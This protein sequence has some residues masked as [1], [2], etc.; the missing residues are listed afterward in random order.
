MVILYL[1]YIKFIKIFR[2]SRYILFS[3]NTAT[4]ITVS[5]RILKA[6]VPK[7]VLQFTMFNCM[8]YALLN[9]EGKLQPDVILMMFPIASIKTEFQLLMILDGK[10]KM[11]KET[12][13][14]DIMRVVPHSS[15]TCDAPL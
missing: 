2:T 7:N 15:W 13:M 5:Q 6:N 4:V 10:F 11:N 3:C 8:F 12:D 9:Q 1:I 14:W